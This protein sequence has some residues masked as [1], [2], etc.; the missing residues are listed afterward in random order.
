MKKK[1]KAQT[2]PKVTKA[3]NSA[4]ST[5]PRPGY[6]VFIVTDD[7]W[8]PTGAAWKHSDG[9]GLNVKLQD[10]RYVLRER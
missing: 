10:C 5:K 9:K 1:Q 3:T 4:K 6:D 8:Q 7:N 2:A